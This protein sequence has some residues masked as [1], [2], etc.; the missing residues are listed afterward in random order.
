MQPATRPRRSLQTALVTVEAGPGETDPLPVLMQVGADARRASA[1]M[2]W[3]E[4]RTLA[5][6]LEH[7]VEDH[8]PDA[9]VQRRGSV[10]PVDVSTSHGH[11]DWQRA[12]VRLGASG[13]VEMTGT[14]VIVEHDTGVNETLRLHAPEGT[15]VEQVRQMVIAAAAAL[16]VMR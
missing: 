12:L 15:R 2:S 9:V 5:D 8:D 11:A 14:S 6:L 7:A 13:T 1:R 3:L 10:A 4:A 16:G